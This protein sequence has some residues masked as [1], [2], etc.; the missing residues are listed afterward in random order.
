[1]RHFLR[2]P[3][4]TTTGL[5]APC[6]GGQPPNS[7]YSPNVSCPG[8]PRNRAHRRYMPRPP[9]M[10]Q[11]FRLDG[12]AYIGDF[13]GGIFECDHVSPWTKSGCNVDAEIVSSPVVSQRALIHVSTTPHPLL[14]RGLRA[15]WAQGRDLARRCKATTYNGVLILFCGVSHKEGGLVSRRSEVRDSSVPGDHRGIAVGNGRLPC[16]CP[17][18]LRP[19]R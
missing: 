9:R 4:V 10:R 16:A 12:Y 6:K 2:G 11:S 17:A 8:P 3:E 1:M 13:H 18:S 14:I 7:D 19:A 15:R 5:T